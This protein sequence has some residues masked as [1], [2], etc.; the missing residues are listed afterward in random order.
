MYVLVFKLITENKLKEVV[1]H[2]WNQRRDILYK[3]EL[4]KSYKVKKIQSWWGESHI[5]TKVFQHRDGG[6]LKSNCNHCGAKNVWLE[7]NT[8]Q[9]ILTN[10]RGWLTLHTCTL[11]IQEIPWGGGYSL[12][13]YGPYTVYAAPKGINGT[14]ILALFRKKGIN[15][16]GH[17]DLKW[18][19]VFVLYLNPW[20]M[21]M[22]M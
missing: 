15:N 17:F 21:Y 22:Y 1:T 13:I 11:K 2:S 18:D 8:N 6:Q 4:I 5:I 12:I 14:C 7:K 10:N 19:M 3:N 16:F 20:Y 9:L